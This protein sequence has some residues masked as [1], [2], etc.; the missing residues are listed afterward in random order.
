MIYL[1]TDLFSP[2][3]TTGLLVNAGEN[4]KKDTMLVQ[5]MNYTFSRSVIRGSAGQSWESAI[6]VCYNWGFD[7]REIDTKNICVWHTSDDT[8]CPPEI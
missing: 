8:F 1:M 7:A 3:S 6:Y 5:M 4:V 2:S